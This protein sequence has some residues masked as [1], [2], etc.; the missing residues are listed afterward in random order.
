MK[1]ME[2][3]QFKR[4]ES[5][6]AQSVRLLQTRVLLGSLCM[7]LALFGALACGG[8]GSTPGQGRQL[9][10]LAVT[11]ANDSA[12]LGTTKQYKATG[13]YS[14]GSTEDLTASATWASSVQNVAGVSNTGGTKGLATPAATGST[15]ISAVSGSKSG[16]T[17]L[18]VT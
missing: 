1:T 16:S 6:L 2:I 5:A 13:N 17:S 8:G 14:D 9:L 10:S 11:P 3:I 15:K 18:T 7:L 4:L 12:P